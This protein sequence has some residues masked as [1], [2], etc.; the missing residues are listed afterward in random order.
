MSEIDEMMKHLD[1]AK[2]V[3]SDELTRRREERAARSRAENGLVD[4]DPEY[5][6]KANYRFF[7]GECDYE[8][9]R[10][11]ARGYVKK[12][13]N[14]PDKIKCRECGSESADVERL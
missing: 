7:C 5:Q 8:A 4:T 2:K 1:A 13:V 3:D 10:I 11:Q 6:K 12:V 14:N 9:Y